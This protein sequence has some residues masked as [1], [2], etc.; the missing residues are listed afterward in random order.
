MST[1]SENEMVDKRFKIIPQREEFKWNLPSSM[2]DYVNLHFRNYIPDK[3]I[4]ENTVP[5]NVQEVPLLGDFAKT[6]LVLQ[7]AIS[8]DHQM[9]KFQEKMLQFMGPLSRLCKGL[10]GV[11]NEYS[12]A[13]EVPVDLFATMIEQNALLLGQ[14]S[15]S[16]SYTHRLQMMKTLVKDPRKVMTLLKGKS[17]ILQESEIQQFGKKFLP[18]MIEI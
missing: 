1:E 6:L 17:A 4:E 3:D 2:A 5:S 14:A 8:T 13:V 11:Q 7:T 10:K 18:H 12:E 9:E 15:L 16:I